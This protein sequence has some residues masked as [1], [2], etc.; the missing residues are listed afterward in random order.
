METITKKEKTT[1]IKSIDSFFESLESEK[2]EAIKLLRQHKKNKKGIS[3]SEI[4]GIAKTIYF[5]TFRKAVNL[6]YPDSDELENNGCINPMDQLF[7]EIKSYGLSLR[8]NNCDLHAFR[9][10][11]PAFWFGSENIFRS[12][13]YKNK[14]PAHPKSDH[15]SL[16][17]KREA[18]DDSKILLE[19]YNSLFVEQYKS[20]MVTNLK[21]SLGLEK[22]G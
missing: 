22:F 14:D 11:N 20:Y 19:K 15:S 13:V 7:D 1:A 2:A 12:E 10:A 8:K 6:K 5:S 18:K 4:E 9:L 16:W 17:R 3:D 21:G